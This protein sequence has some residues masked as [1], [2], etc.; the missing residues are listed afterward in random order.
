MRG[1][2]AWSSARLTSFYFMSL[3]ESNRL[4]DRERRREKYSC[5]RFPTEKKIVAHQ[6]RLR[7][8]E[9]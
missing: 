7:F 1:A 2:S 4:C 9:R 3:W 6:L 8:S 5:M